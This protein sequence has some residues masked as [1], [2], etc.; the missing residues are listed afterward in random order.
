MLQKKIKQYDFR[1][2]VLAEKVSRILTEAILEDVLKGG[3]KL[4]ES[5]LQKQ[6]GISRSPLREAF[7]DLEKKGLVTITPRKGTFVKRI[8]R[9]DIQEN[10][11]VRATLEGL[12]AKEAFKKMDAKDRSRLEQALR[13]MEQAVIEDDPKAYWKQHI[14]F[15]ETFIGACDN[16]V[17]IHILHTLRMH[18]LWYRFSYQYYREDL[19]GSLAVH[20]KIL[21]LFNNPQTDPAAL[22]VLVQD[23]IETA[24]EKFLAY[25]EEP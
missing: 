16:D 6:F 24:A 21:D 3:D 2:D 8:S 12:A 9:K 17:L 15:H 19:P 18:S 10:F 22:A 5:D 20:K 14:V 7:R 13:K 4:V 25:L 1:P 23:H 11:P